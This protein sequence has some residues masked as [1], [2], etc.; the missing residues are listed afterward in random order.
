M[1][2]GLVQSYVVPS[3]TVCKGTVVMIYY[4]YLKWNIFPLMV[5]FHTLN[6]CL[7][8]V[9]YKDWVMATCAED[10]LID[11]DISARQFSGTLTFS[12]ETASS[13]A[14]TDGMKSPHN[15]FF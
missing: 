11:D 12:A 9:C 7:V 2:G 6:L 3:E 1:L 15:W 8:L 14:E 5:V 10:Y 4:K 13:Q